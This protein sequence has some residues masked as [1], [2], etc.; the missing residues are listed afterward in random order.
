[1]RLTDP[2]KARA[3]LRLVDLLEELEDVQAVHA[4]YEID[5]ALMEQLA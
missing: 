2:E 3:M 1:M 5:D 4:N